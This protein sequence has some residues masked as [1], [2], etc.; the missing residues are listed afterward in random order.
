MVYINHMWF[1]GRPILGLCEAGAGR[2]CLTE[3]V[4]FGE[5]AMVGCQA[6]AEIPNPTIQLYLADKDFLFAHRGR[7]EL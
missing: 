3:S 5:T 1:D 2:G 4:A 6:L 7:V